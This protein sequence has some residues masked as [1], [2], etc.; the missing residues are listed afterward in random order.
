MASRTA[1]SKCPKW[2]LQKEIICEVF[3]LKRLLSASCMRSVIFIGS[4]SKSLRLP[5]TQSE[6]A[7]EG[8][9]VS[10]SHQTL[11]VRTDENDFQLFVFDRETTK[12]QTITTGTRVRVT[13][14]RGDE[15]GTRLA[16]TVTV[17][18][19]SPE[20]KS[21]TPQSQAKPLPPA[22]RD[23]EQDIK[24]RSPTL[25]PRCT[26]GCRSRSRIVHVWSAL[27][28]WSDLQSKAILFRPNAEF[29]FGEVTDLIALNLEGCLQIA[30]VVAGKNWSA[31]IGAGTRFHISAPK[32]RAS[33]GARQEHRLWQLRL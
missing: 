11:V 3:Y 29:A 12:P 25:A 1:L 2:A 15:E 31:Y 4:M 13:S 17:L 27:S 18:E 33:A 9:V 8:T 7:I 10:T 28:D 32:F 22:V 5:P 21:G 14:T 19:S 23:L 16:S 6:N 26:C 20:A 24:A 30:C